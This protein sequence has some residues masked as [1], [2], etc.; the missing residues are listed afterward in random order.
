ML[1]KVHFQLFAAKPPFR[2]RHYKILNCQKDNKSWSYHWRFL[3]LMFLTLCISLIIW[4]CSYTIAE[5][6][7]GRLFSNYCLPCYPDHFDGTYPE[8]FRWKFLKAI[9]NFSVAAIICSL[10][11]I[12]TM[13]VLEDLIWIFDKISSS[14]I[15]K[16]YKNKT[17]KR[18]TVLKLDKIKKYQP[19]RIL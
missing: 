7:N 10:M 6:L 14:L 8:Y 17:E 11:I 12:F 2:M 19:K 15:R 4:G 16:L 9:R 1:K 3:L 13:N 18:Y 5:H